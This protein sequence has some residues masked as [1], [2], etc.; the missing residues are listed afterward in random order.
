MSV[1]NH[2]PAPSVEVTWFLEFISKWTDGTFLCQL[3]PQMYLK[4]YPMWQA[5]YRSWFS[6]AK[7]RACQKM[8]WA[9]NKINLP[10]YVSSGSLRV[11][12]K[13]VVSQAKGQPTFLLAGAGYGT[14]RIPEILRSLFSVK[15]LA[16]VVILNPLNALGDK[17]VVSWSLGS[18]KKDDFKLMSPSVRCVSI[19]LW[20][21]E[22]FPQG[23][24]LDRA[25]LHITWGKIY[26]KGHL[27]INLS[28]TWYSSFFP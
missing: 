7:P 13:S 9:P 6:I 26:W 27:L 22:G 11:T 20:K 17:K 12:S 28:G 23:G 16:I 10:E 19:G 3:A 4:P 15:S 24:Q 2:P 5:I 25:E 18:L 14:T 21:E 8:S 1:W